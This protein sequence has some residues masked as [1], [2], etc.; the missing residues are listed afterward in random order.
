MTPVQL[1]MARAALSLGIRD[2][3]KLARVSHDTITRIETGDETLK[4]STVDKVRAALE[5]AGV[6][7]VADNG[8]GP[9]VRLRKGG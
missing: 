8:E 6:V 3:A 7:F 9:G 4:E 5:A 1:K 2:T